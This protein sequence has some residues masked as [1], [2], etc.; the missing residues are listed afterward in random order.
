MYT[1][2]RRHEHRENGLLVFAAERSVEQ[3]QTFFFVVLDVVRVDHLAGVY[4]QQKFFLLFLHPVYVLDLSRPASLLFLAFLQF[5]A[6]LRLQ[7]ISNCS[8][9]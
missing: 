5:L 7:R 2:N 6:H 9:T 4:L 8:V 1:E 3:L